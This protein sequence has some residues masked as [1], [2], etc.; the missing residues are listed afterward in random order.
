MSTREKRH[1]HD[2]EAR[3]GIRRARG[4]YR[5]V[6]LV[7]AASVVGFLVA[8]T[9][10]LPYR[11]AAK[12]VAVYPH[13]TDAFTQGLVF[14]GP[15]LYESTGLYGESSLRR[16]DLETGEV[17]QMQRL[18]DDYFAE[19]C[20]VWDEH[21]IQLTWKAGVGFVYDK[22][23]FAFEREFTYAGE[24][25][26]LTHDGERLIMSDGSSYLRF[27]DPE[28]F[29]ETG[30]IQ[31]IDEGAPVEQLNELEWTQGE[32]WAN[33]WQRPEV[34]RV[35]AETGRVLG[36][37]DFSEL[38]EREPSGVLNGI[39]VRGRRVFVTGKRWT[40]IYEVKIKPADSS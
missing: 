13:A 15:T 18:P 33:V 24:G 21:I 4:W 1:H 22:E 23:S 30:R 7:L 8:C 20:T 12:V 39:A 16:V 9:P 2:H 37:I 17:L 11:A 35:E 28:T 31:V 14:D 29:E 5:S 40:S 26:G 6:R 34:V 32:V 38:V 36:W 10:T 27:L 25:W 3:S 19:G